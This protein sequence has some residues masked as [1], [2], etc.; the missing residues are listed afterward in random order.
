MRG[1][2]VDNAPGRVGAPL[3]PFLRRF[4][5]AA[6]A[7]RRRGRIERSG[8]AGGTTEYVGL[9]GAEGVGF[10]ME[11]RLRPFRRKLPDTRREALFERSGA[12]RIRARGAQK[13]RSRRKAGWG[14]EAKG[15]DPRAEN[16][17]ALRRGH[18]GDGRRKPR[19]GRQGTTRRTAGRT[20]RLTEGRA[21]AQKRGR[22]RQT[23]TSLLAGRAAERPAPNTAA[24]ATTKKQPNCGSRTAA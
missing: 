14:A 13:G 21:E 15:P 3:S 22:E 8:T 1:A 5:G 18:Q 6:P 11:F 24:G 23:T 9:T 19:G 10:C 20:L 12:G 2:Q 4:E 7:A 17:A 16:S